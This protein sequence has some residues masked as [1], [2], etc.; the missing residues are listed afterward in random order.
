MKFK[1]DVGKALGL[2][3]L[4]L[5]F[6]GFQLWGQTITIRG[7]VTNEAGETLPG[8]NV[9]LQ[10]TFTGT[11]TDVNGNFTITTP[12]DG[13]LLFSFVGFRNLVVPVEGRQV[14]NVTLEPD[15][16]GLDEF[17]VVGYGVQRKSDITGAITSVDAARL[18]DVPAHNLARA[19]QGKAS[20]LEIQNTSPRPGGGS[21][22]RIRGERSLSA[23]NDPLIVLD[24]IPF[25]GSLND[26]SMDD[27]ESVEV[28]KDA[29]ATVIFGS[30]GANGVILINTKRG[31][32]GDLRVTYN[33]YQGLSTVARKYELFSAEEFI[34]LRN[35]A[36]YTN[37]LANEKE[38]MLLGRETDWQ[39]LVYQ[40]GLTSN[41]EF[42]LSAGTAKTQY[43]VSGGYFNET[44]VLPFMGFS[45]YSLRAAIDQ[46]IGSRLRVGFTSLNSVSITDAQSANPMWT[47][48]T[49]SPL[50]SPY[51]MDGTVNEQPGYDT[52]ITYSPLVL[53]D[54]TRWNEQNR[55]LASFNMFYAE[56]QVSPSLINRVN[57]G[58]SFAD[59][60]YNSFFGSHTPFRDGRENAAQVNNND[61]FN[62]TVENL[63]TFNRTFA[64]RHRVNLTGMASVQE[65]ISTGSRVDLNR[66]PVDY[67]QFN[68]PFLAEV[69]QAPS[70]GNFFS[71]WRLVSFMARANYVF[72]D[73]YMITISG[74]ADGSSRLAPGNKW[75]AYPAVAL[76]WNIMN[77]QFMQNAQFVDN[78]R[79]R[80][81]YGQ[82][83]NT[84][85]SPF[86]T[87]G[88]LTG[89]FY[90]FGAR[91][92]RGYYVSTL[93]NLELGWEHTTTT[94]VGVDFAF[95]AGRIY[96]SVDAY[97]QQTSDLL[98]AKQLPASIG[99]PGRFMTNVGKTEN[100]G[101]EIVLN[102]VALSPQNEGDLGWEINVNAFFNR[103]KIVALQDPTITRD[104]GN[105]WFVGQP[106][107]A[108]YDYYKLG[109]WQ[110]DQADLAAQYG[111]APGR[112]RLLD[113]AGGGV[114]GDEPDGR[115]TAADRRILGSSEPDIQGGFTSTWR[116]RGFDLSVVAYFRLGGMLISTLHM[117]TDY[118][119]RLDGRRNGIR[120][121]YW[122]PDNPTNDMPMPH[123]SFD[124]SFTSVLGYFDAS[125]GKIRSIN[126][127]Y[128]VNPRFTRFLG[129]EST[130]RVFATVEDPFLLFSPYVQA[131]GV[132]PE[133][134]RTGATIQGGEG[135]PERALKIGLD[136][137]PTR[138]F[139]FGINYK[140]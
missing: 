73:R 50:S 12:G 77:E 31:R 65:N 124:P 108:I 135:V 110:L 30:R 51:N 15:I 94:N 121:D 38:S 106:M 75:H 84:A 41:H 138:K 46:T 72:D 49:F 89:T 104:I 114:N 96:G 139:I 56:L 80:F 111:F 91:G 122:T 37:F 9:V 131:G 102:G 119:N 60:K 21:Q 22:L 47:V 76:G 40:T 120:V 59:N 19:L 115:I 55:R 93:P 71:D 35:V 105:G 52:E 27:I 63:L 61:N 109:I 39:D 23:S 137:P 6:T 24:G 14:V 117:P 45:R 133:P 88:G 129:G 126:L 103:G 44:G 123:R 83:A 2:S 17:V 67:L 25:P 101:L 86:A 1:K 26:I 118:L 13:T 113:F 18:R 112:V 130:L 57:V 74:R 16:L 125:F 99:V 98:L 29:S 4:A 87:L 11:I 66:I 8:V 79:L 68:N 53:Q 54:R 132:N 134:N 82:A 136:V 48:L 107:S 92:V 140:F 81:G 7:N 33:A 3:L 32:Q 10:G 127:G 42:T 62:Y 70:S 95:F 100:R 97:L 36:G 116:F 43:S 90:N 34:K 85:V 64:Q 128:N 58:V 5:F 69:I 28:L 20:G 78:L